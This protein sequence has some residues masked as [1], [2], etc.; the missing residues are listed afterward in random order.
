MTLFRVLIAMVVAGAFVAFLI[1][2]GER[3]F[4]VS[5]LLES[6]Q[7]LF[8]FRAARPLLT[9]VLYLMT[10][11]LAT[12]ASLP[13]AGISLLVGGALFGTFLGGFLGL[14]GATVGGTAAFWSSRFVF[15]GYLERRYAGALYRLNT[16]MRENAFNYMLFL[17]IAPIFPF[18]II[19]VVLGLTQM[20]TAAFFLG[21]FFGLMPSSLVLAHAGKNLVAVTRLQDVFSTDILF[22]LVLLGFISLV[23]VVFKKLRV[24]LAKR[25]AKTIDL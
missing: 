20:S 16:E 24:T 6:R 14:L 3:F 1:L 5:F 11:I 8:D 19:N 15:R 4:S 17:R 13:G 10:V 18:F 21:T 2:N 23:P 9:I 22:S 25:K 7:R 12:A